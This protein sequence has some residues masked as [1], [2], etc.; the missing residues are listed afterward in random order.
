MPSTTIVVPCYNEA[1]R[2]QSSKFYDFAKM[3]H[4]RRLVFVNDGSR[5][6]TMRLLSE[7]ASRCPARITA[8]DQPSNQGKAEAVRLGMLHAIDQGADYVG[9]WDA[10]LATPLHASDEF[11]W[12]L[13][14]RPQIDMVIGS[15]MRLAGRRIERSAKRWIAGLAF[16]RAASLILRLRLRD[17]QC[18]AKLFRVTPDLVAVLSAPFEARWIFDVEIFARMKLVLDSHGAS[19]LSRITYELPLDEWRDVAGSKIKPLDF[20][21]A[22]A[23]LLRIWWRYQWRRD[24]AI[25][26]LD[27]PSLL[28]MPATIALHGDGT[29]RLSAGTEFEA[30]RAK[31]A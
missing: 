9:F 28:P 17:T 3:P 24:F 25:R 22:G 10:D 13:D 30:S 14:R 23:E 11:C 29:P 4:G 1:Q 20:V 18:G 7:L 26:G 31:A 8:L 12:V 15:R 27:G 5:D 21:T 16:A 2:L 19:R 6:D